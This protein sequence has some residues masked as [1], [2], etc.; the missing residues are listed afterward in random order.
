MKD[1]IEPVM[2]GGITGNGRMLCSIREDGSLHRLFWPRIDW[3]QHMGILKIGVQEPGR[4]VAWL[5]SE[6]FRY[7]RHYHEN[8]NI[9]TTEMVNV[10]DG[11]EV[12]QTDFV[13]P[14]RDVLVRLYSI[15]NN[16][17]ETRTFNLIAYLSLS[18][19]E[20]ANQDCMRYLDD[21]KTLMQYRRDVYIALKSPDRSPFGF[22]CGRRNAPS[23]PF[24]RANYGE[25][26]GNPNN[27]KSGAGAVGWETGAVEPGGRASVSLILSAAHN[28]TELIELM[29]LPFAG[30]ENLAR[31]TKA[32][33]RGWLDTPG[34]KKAPAHPCL[35]G[36]L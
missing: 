26:Y 13:L 17:S 1:F 16:G 6:L 15:K 29:N 27:I 25:L 8:T 9:Y 4:S 21:Q 14:D 23:D 30:G 34:K 18:L 12:S 20:S 28:E 19:D 5:D 24:E 33:W 36:R 35:T 22:N 3:G 2:P 7:S 10:R 32:Y 31:L 11:I